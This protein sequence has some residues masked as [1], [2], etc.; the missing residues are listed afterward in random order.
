MHTAHH[1][2]INVRPRGQKKMHHWKNLHYRLQYLPNISC[3]D[4][5]NS[6]KIY[7]KKLYCSVVVFYFIWVHYILHVYHMFQPFGHHQVSYNVLAWLLLFYIGQYLHVIFCIMCFLRGVMPLYMSFSLLLKY[8]N[9]MP[10]S[11][12][13]AAREAPQRHQLLGNVDVL[14]WT[15]IC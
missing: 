14:M 3:V 5:Y 11:W 10:E 6:I 9:M 2:L 7:L 4:H 8:C 15:K 1:V 13:C 12:D